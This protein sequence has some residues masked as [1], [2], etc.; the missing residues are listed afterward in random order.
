MYKTTTDFERITFDRHVRSAAQPSLHGLF[1][2][3]GMQRS[4]VGHFVLEVKYDQH[5][6]FPSW[7]RSFIAEHGLAR[8]ALSKYWTCATSHALASGSAARGFAVIA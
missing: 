3:R 5:F 1:A 8:R 4:L 2:E 6:G 7:L